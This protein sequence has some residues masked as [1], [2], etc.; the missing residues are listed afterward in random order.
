MSSI[1]FCV[2]DIPKDARYVPFKMD[3]CLEANLHL[4]FI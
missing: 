2:K 3:V 4:F 1:S